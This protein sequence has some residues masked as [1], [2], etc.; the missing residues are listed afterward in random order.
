MFSNIAS[1]DKYF[2]ENSDNYRLFYTEWD[3]DY[4]GVLHT[5]DYMIEACDTNI[6]C[7]K[8]ASMAVLM[9]HPEYIEY[10]PD[11]F[12]KKLND[13]NI[14]YFVQKAVENRQIELSKEQDE[15][16]DI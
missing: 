4:N 6:E 15:K 10:Y 11:N 7:D 14:G 8:F 12:R 13:L 5:L 16:D 1:Y 9:A 2:Y 3:A